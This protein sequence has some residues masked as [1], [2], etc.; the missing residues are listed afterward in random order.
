MVQ[1]GDANPK[2][3]GSNPDPENNFSFLIFR[4]KM[5]LSNG[6]QKTV[7]STSTLSN[8][9]KHTHAGMN[10]NAARERERGKKSQIS[11]TKYMFSSPLPSLFFEC[12]CGTGN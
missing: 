7:N 3:L 10:T 11:N 12:R 5:L 2:V 8:M 9:K 1:G 4:K 6:P